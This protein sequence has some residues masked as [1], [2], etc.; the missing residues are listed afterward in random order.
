MCSSIFSTFSSVRFSVVGFMLR[1][2]IHLNLSF[3]QGDRYGSIFILPNIVIQLGHHHLLNML[4]SFYMFC[5]FVKNQVIVGMWINIWVFDSVPFVLL[6]IFMPIPGCFQY[7]SYVVE[8]EV[9]NCEVSLLYRIVWAT[10]GF[11]IFQMKLIIV[12]S[13]FVKNFAG[14]LM[15]IANLLVRLPFLLC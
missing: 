10:L 15:G 9:R 11:L 8:F 6:S 4:F 12:I 14:I 13:R 2:L 7:G 3:V 5:F 1:S